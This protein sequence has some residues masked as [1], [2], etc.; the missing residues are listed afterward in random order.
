MKS[1]I[2][3]ILV[4]LALIVQPVT[5]C[6]QIWANDASVIRASEKY[7]RTK[8]Y[9]S[10]LLLSKQLKIGM[11]QK[12]VEQLLGVPDA[13]VVEGQSCY[14]SNKVSPYDKTQRAHL[15]IEYRKIEY[16]KDDILV[17]VTGKVE[18]FHFSY[19]TVCS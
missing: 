10:L 13:M 16:R 14:L 2:L 18:S 7:R 19:S 17:T 15:Q 8:D 11:P 6:E 12:Q 3:L 5:G 9:D 1:K 4:V